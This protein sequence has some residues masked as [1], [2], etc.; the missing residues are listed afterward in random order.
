MEKMNFP[1]G[2]RTYLP[3][4]ALFFLLVFLMP[5]SP[6]FNFDF[7]K[8]SPWMYETLVAQFD[9]PV[10]KTEQQLMLEKEKVGSEVIPYYRYEPKVK[11]IVPGDNPGI[12]VLVLKELY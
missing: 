12:T 5:R 9:F 11:R 3:L 8:G 7:K 2:I 10:L 4:I 1:K 6:K